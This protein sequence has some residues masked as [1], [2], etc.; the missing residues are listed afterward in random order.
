MDVI[1][2]M[3]FLQYKANVPIYYVQVPNLEKYTTTEKDS[4]KGISRLPP[5]NQRNRAE[6]LFE[7][8][9]ESPSEVLSA[10]EVEKLDEDGE[11]DMF[12]TRE[13]LEEKIRR[14]SK[15]IRVGMAPI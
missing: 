9:E 13:D 15:Q 5:P 8:K 11:I 12:V 2:R 3:Y 10:L 7:V 1:K 6:D 14:R 4:Q